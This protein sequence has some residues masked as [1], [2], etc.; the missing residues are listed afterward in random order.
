[1]G[2]TA[3]APAFPLLKCSVLHLCLRR[4]DDLML[5]PNLVL[6]DIPHQCCHLCCRPNNGL[7]VPLVG[8]LYWHFL[9]SSY[10][11]GHQPPLQD[12]VQSICRALMTTML[13]EHWPQRMI[14][15]AGHDCF[16]WPRVDV[17][18]VTMLGMCQVIVLDCCWGTMQAFPD[19]SEGAGCLKPD[20][21]GHCFA[22]PPRS[23]QVS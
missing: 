1:M 7:P 5:L 12:E 22:L 6:Q 14:Y 11:L 3:S 18:V 21:L 17:D 16:S 8:N 13:N 20:H 9:Y 10:S 23:K 2:V 15:V 4:H 19:R